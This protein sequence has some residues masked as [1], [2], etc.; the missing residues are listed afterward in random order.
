MKNEEY[1][2]M[3]DNTVVYFGKKYT[4]VPLA[5]HAK[6]KI[7][8]IFAFNQ[9]L[10]KDETVQQDCI[11]G[12]FNLYSVPK[13]LKEHF[14]EITHQATIFIEHSLKNSDLEKQVFIDVYPDF[15]YANITQNGRLLFSN[16]F[17]Y[18]NA[19]EFVYFV[20]NIFDKFGLNQLENKLI[21]SGE[22]D[23]KDDK[24]RLLKDYIKFL[25]LNS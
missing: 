24:I 13:T 2:I 17:E 3:K 15:F 22:T 12:I 19:E 23:K 21:I 11:D 10:G 1:K 20:L 7:D 4:L 8:E 25:V 18:A 5:L 14:S 6:N 9:P 16:A